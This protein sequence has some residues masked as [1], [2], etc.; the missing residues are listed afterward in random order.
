MKQAGELPAD[1]LKIDLGRLL[2]ERMPQATRVLPKYIADNLERWGL[3]P[4]R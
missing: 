2:V 4:V 1:L 3:W